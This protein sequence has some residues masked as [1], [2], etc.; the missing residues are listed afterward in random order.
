MKFRLY[1]VVLSSALLLSACAGVNNAT[2]SEAK[3]RERAAFA[4]GVNPSAV[5]IS[6]RRNEGI[7]IYF[8]ATVGGR[9]S[10]CYVTNSVTVIGA[11][12]SDALCSGG[13]A[14][15]ATRRTGQCNALLKAAGR[16]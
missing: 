2:V 13:G 6:N 14:R 11:V 16:C 4:L 7:T 1:A 9:S 12:T 5:S 15:E 10:Q 8:T 3:L